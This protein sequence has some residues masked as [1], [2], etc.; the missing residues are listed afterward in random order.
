MEKTPTASNRVELRR[1][2]LL[3]A[4]TCLV[5][6][7]LLGAS[8]FC[9]TR[10]R[11]VFSVVCG[12][13]SKVDFAVN[14]WAATAGKYLNDEVMPTNAWVAYFLGKRESVHGEILEPP[15][16][17]GEPARVRLTRRLLAYPPGTRIYWPDSASIRLIIARP[18]GTPK[19]YGKTNAD[20]PY[21]RNVTL[22][23]LPFAWMFLEARTVD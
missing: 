18:Q 9:Y 13:A 15:R 12:Q 22:P 10:E 4:L 3:F 20:L 2:L 19:H 21:S 17:V 14:E 8:W 5:Y 11:A 16:R 23:F 7:V 1:R 6:L